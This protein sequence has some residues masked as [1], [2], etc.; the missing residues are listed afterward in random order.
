ME[1]LGSLHPLRKPAAAQYFVCVCLCMYMLVS[2]TARFSSHCM[3]S[4]YLLL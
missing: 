2:K 4:G 1:N 3:L